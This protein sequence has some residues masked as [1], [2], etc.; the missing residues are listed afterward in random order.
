MGLA[1][2]ALSALLLARARKKN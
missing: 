1:S 2:A